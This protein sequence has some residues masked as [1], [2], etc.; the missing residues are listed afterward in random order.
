MIANFQEY[1]RERK[2]GLDQAFLAELY[3]LLRNSGGTY[4]EMVSSTLEGGKR[5]RGCLLCLINETLDGKPEAG[6]PRAVAV[7]LIHT[8]SLI[9][10]D[11]VDQDTMRRR[12]PATWTLEGARRAVL[13]G[14][15]IFASAIKR[16]NDL[17][18]EDGKVVSDAIAQVA[19]GALYEPLD[20]GAL[21]H[22]LESGKPA[23]GLYDKI[24]HLKSGKLFAAA[25]E[26]GAIAAGKDERVRGMFRRY[27]SLVG[28][29]YQIADDLQE[30]RAHLGRGSIEPEEM[31]VLA[32]AL[33]Y[34]VEEMRPG[35]IEIL[36]GRCPD[37]AESV[38][39]AI[40][41][42]AGLMEKE[43]DRRLLFAVSALEADPQDKAV[44]LLKRAPK[45]LIRM[46]NSA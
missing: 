38:L 36:Q 25:C 41:T 45:D 39:A 5:I 10:D 16:M 28:E 17:S 15:V 7:E 3:G 24:I 33:L 46:F 13:L 12:M 34:F 29:A 8:A 27:G 23:P 18:R 22:E 2:P 4:H 31:A 20:P 40:R 44:G 9:H 6:I 21:I 42:A 37:R 1:V 43:I 11:F 14:D 26:L 35:I 19:R 32:P 30:I